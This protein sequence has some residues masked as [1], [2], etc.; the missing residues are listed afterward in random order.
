MPPFIAQP[1]RSRDA[2]QAVGAGEAGEREAADVAASLDVLDRRDE[3]VD[4]APPP[5]GWDEE[6]AADE[7]GGTPDS[8]ALA[9]SPEP[10][11]PVRESSDGWMTAAEELSLAESPPDAPGLYSEAEAPAETTGGW[12]ELFGQPGDDEG[13]ETDASADVEAPAVEPPLLAETQLAGE[14][15]E[16]ADVAGD[17]VRPWEWEGAPAPQS[18]HDAPPDEPSAGEWEPETLEDVWEASEAAE[19]TAAADD[20]A[21][22][23]AAPDAENDP[24]VAVEQLAL[25]Q[26][27][28]RPGEDVWAAHAFDD[29]VATDAE[30]RPVAERV[31][32]RLEDLARDVRRRGLTALGAGVPADEEAGLDELSRLIAAVV[33]GFYGREE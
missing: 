14:V 27:A 30:G 24:D 32:D 17:T 1:A 13:V 29:R 11:A 4:I 5:A 12:A 21:D 31:A 22:W 28:V 25:Q 19:P 23:P 3:L 8:A 7:Q 10:E 20:V 2:P 33:A 6:H 9:A 18:V 16:V 26:P 15:A